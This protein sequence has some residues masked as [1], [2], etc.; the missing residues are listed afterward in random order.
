MK[1]LIIKTSSFGWNSIVLTS[2]TLFK[3]ASYRNSYC[4]HY[5]SSFTFALDAITLPGPAIRT[6]FIFLCKA[7]GRTVHLCGGKLW[8]HIKERSHSK[9]KECMQ[10]ALKINCRGRCAASY[11]RSVM[12]CIHPEVQDYTSSQQQ[13]QACWVQTLINLHILFRLQQRYFPPPAPLNA[14]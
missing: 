5:K 7:W 2:D 8:N 14:W 3:N 11:S 12:S 4:K 10:L 13:Q 6:M 1:T 9:C